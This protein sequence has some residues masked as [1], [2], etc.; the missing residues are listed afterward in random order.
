MYFVRRLA[1]LLI[2]RTRAQIVPCWKLAR[3]WARSHSL[4]RGLG[5]PAAV[6]RPLRERN[7]LQLAAGA[8]AR[9]ATTCSPLSVRHVNAF[10]VSF[11]AIG[12]RRATGFGSSLA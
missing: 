1:G 7:L 8:L 12:A 10:V 2:A 6:R 3:R 11:G 4:A 9:Q 5:T